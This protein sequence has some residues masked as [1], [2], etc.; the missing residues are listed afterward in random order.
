MM[1]RWSDYTFPDCYFAPPIIVF[2]GLCLALEERKKYMNGNFYAYDNDPQKCARPQYFDFFK[3][4]DKYVWYYLFDCNMLCLGYEDNN[5]KP[6]TL[7]S[8][9]AELN[10]ELI[11]GPY[12]FTPSFSCAWA[13]QRYRMI[14]LMTRPPHLSITGY[15]YRSLIF[16]DENN[17][18]DYS[19]GEVQKIEDNDMNSYYR[20]DLNYY[21][22]K[23]YNGSFVIKNYVPD[24]FFVQGAKYKEFFYVNQFHL[25][26]FG[27]P[28]SG[29]GSYCLSADENG[30]FFEVPEKDYF[31]PYEL[32]STQS[33]YWC[34]DYWDASEHPLQIQ[35]DVSD[36]LEFY[37]AP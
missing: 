18:S 33:V 31:V 28:F 17:C 24:R 27:S 26:S 30:V 13:K 7:E 20:A 32:S 15:D 4:E 23:I 1:S 21:G 12:N 36:I 34:S 25:E 19:Y 35:I 29:V 3:N 8:M 11:A 14:N 10:E 2:E 37:D 5:N 9:A 22:Y 16:P 6:Y